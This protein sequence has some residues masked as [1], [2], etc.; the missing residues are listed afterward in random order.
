MANSSFF[1]QTD[2]WLTHQLVPCVGHAHQPFMWH[3]EQAK[4]EGEKK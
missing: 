4:K 2:P 1:K 3:G